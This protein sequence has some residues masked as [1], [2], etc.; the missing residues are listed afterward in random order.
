MNTLLQYE[1]ENNVLLHKLRTTDA[2]KDLVK[3]IHKN[4]VL[5]P[6]VVNERNCIQCESNYYV[7][8]GTFFNSLLTGNTFASTKCYTGENRHNC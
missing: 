8:Q 5:Y 3:L 6:S 1:E 7:Y 2:G 4:E